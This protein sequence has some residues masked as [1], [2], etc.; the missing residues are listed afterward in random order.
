MTVRAVAQ[1][2][3][4]VAGRS[5]Y[6]DIGVGGIVDEAYCPFIQLA[7][8]RYQPHSLDGLTLP[9]VVLSDLSK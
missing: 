7:L 2:A 5:W 1:L 3:D 9:P 8:A 4:T 6:A